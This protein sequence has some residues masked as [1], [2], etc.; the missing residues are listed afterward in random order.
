MFSG[1]IIQ[2]QL[3]ASNIAGIANYARIATTVP[4]ERGFLGHILIEDK[5]NLSWFNT[6]GNWTRLNGE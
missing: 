4:S 2:D 6:W 1:R 5:N 3:T